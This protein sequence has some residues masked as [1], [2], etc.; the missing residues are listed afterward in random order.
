MKP[1]SKS[2]LNQGLVDDRVFFFRASTAKNRVHTRAARHELPLRHPPG[3][4]QRLMVLS[5]IPRKNG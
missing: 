5:S 4:S 1:Y 2:K 3:S